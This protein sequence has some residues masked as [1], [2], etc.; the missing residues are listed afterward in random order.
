MV[1][2]P[3]PVAPAVIVSQAALLDADHPQ[4]PAV[5]TSKAPAPPPAGLEAEAADSENVQP[6]PWLTVKVRPAIVSV[7]ERDGPVV[8]ATVKLT[9]PFP[10]PLAPDAIVIHASLLAAD[11]AHPDPA[12]TPTEP[13]APEA[14]T[15]C[16]SGAIANAQ[17]CPWTTVTV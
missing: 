16:V 8:D 13:A 2:F 4:P 15:F 12:V 17:P 14:G 11:Q 7:P 1:P 3:L 6:C 10:V 5:R 9:V